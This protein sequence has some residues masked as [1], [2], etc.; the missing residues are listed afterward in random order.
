M[1]RKCQESFPRHRLQ[2]KAL[3]SD[4]RMHVPWCMSESLTRGGEE[5]APGITGACATRNLTYL[6]RG[7][8]FFLC[9]L[10]TNK[11]HSPTKSRE[12]YE[13]KFPK[14]PTEILAVSYLPGHLRYWC[15][16]YCRPAE[17]R[18]KFHSDTIIITSNLAASGL[19]E[20]LQK[21]V[22]PLTE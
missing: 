3:V 21:D 12:F 8:L 19:H 1:H 16:V 2:G 15:N 17:I 14:P 20:I 10:V 11:T 7:P 22:R 9:S 4:P 13:K 6:V 5:K 18:V